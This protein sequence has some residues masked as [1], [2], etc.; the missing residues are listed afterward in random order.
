MAATPFA[1][2]AVQAA[3]HPRIPSSLSLPGTEFGDNVLPFTLTY[4]TETDTIPYDIRGFAPSPLHGD[5]SG[6]QEARLPVYIFMTGNGNRVSAHAKVLKFASQMAKR[7]FLAAVVE[8]PGMWYLSHG[9]E[10][11]TTSD[12][13]LEVSLK[14][15]GGSTSLLS[16]ANRTF[17]YSGQGDHSRSALATICRDPRADCSRGI[18]LHGHSLGGHLVALAPRFATGVTAALITS[19]GT[20][21]PGT[22]SCCGLASGERS[23]C[24]VDGVVGGAA[25]ECEHD[26]QMSEYLPRSRRRLVITADDNLYGDCTVIGDVHCE[27]GSYQLNKTGVLAQARL[28]SGY[29]CGEA[30]SCLMEDGSGYYLPEAGRTNGHAYPYEMPQHE[31][32]DTPLTED[33]VRTD[34]PWGMV[35]SATWLEATGKRPL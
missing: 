32:G 27:A 18:A 8:T 4:Q 17:A 31:D 23:C 2:A 26:V 9:P 13:N 35:P 28:S 29:D 14:C 21:V 30:K 1:V 3:W 24:S 19:A 7:G 11:R 6:R 22:D 10:N 34:E 20:I 16:L 12:A 25:L 33:F 15:A 5:S